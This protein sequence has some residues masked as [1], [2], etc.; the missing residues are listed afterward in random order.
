MTRNAK[1]LTGERHTTHGLF[2]NVA[3]TSAGLLAVMAASPNWSTMSVQRR[4]AIKM[5]VHKLGRIGAGDASHPDHWDDIGGYALL[6]KQDGQNPPVQLAAA[7]KRPAKK[8]RTAKKSAAKKVTARP[9]RKTAKKAERQPARRQR[10][11]RVERRARPAS[12]AA[13]PAQSAEAA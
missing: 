10:S 6:G 4:E 12:V 3:A 9:A 13:A 2:E 8:T 7:R 11:A 1:A 5:I